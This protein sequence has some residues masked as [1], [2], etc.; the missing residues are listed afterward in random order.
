MNRAEWYAVL[1]GSL[2]QDRDILRI[3][4]ALTG[5]IQNIA[6]LFN[7]RML[8]AFPELGLVRIFI[9]RQVPQLDSVVRFITHTKALML[10][11]LRICQE[12][13]LLCRSQ[14]TQSLLPLFFTVFDTGIQQI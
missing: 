1:S 8:C 10:Q 9:K 11:E 7:M 12:W 13:S 5:I 14:N 6:L 3:E 4:R 2:L